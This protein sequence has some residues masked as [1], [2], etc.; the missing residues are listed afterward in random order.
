M[1]VSHPSSVLEKGRSFTFY[2]THGHFACHTNQTALEVFRAA[3][4][5]PD[6]IMEWYGSSM[7][8]LNEHGELKATKVLSAG[9]VA[10]DPCGQRNG[11]SLD[12]D[13]DDSRRRILVAP[14][15]GFGIAA[16]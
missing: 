10:G 6:N 12:V 8:A 16:W 7:S 3:I 15:E 13:R 14:E 1:E 5:R 2:N 9:A 4:R 11:H